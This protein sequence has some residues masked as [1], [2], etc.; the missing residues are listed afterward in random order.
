MSSRNDVKQQKI[1]NTPNKEWTT[2]RITRETAELIRRS[3]V[4]GDNNA[5]DVLHRILSGI[6]DVW[7]EFLAIDGEGPKTSPREIFFQLGE[8][9]YKPRFY[10]FKNGVIEQISKPPKLVI[11]E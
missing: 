7:V 4:F 2:V 11:Q 1:E 9:D 8:S 5:D 6:A 3:Y 10:R